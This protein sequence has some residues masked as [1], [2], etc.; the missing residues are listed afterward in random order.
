[1][2]QTIYTITAQTNL[3]AGSGDANYGIIDKL[4]QRDALTG[5]PCI[6]AS[7]L[8]G[9]ILQHCFNSGYD[10]DNIE[11]IFG[12]QPE[13]RRKGQPKRTQSQT[14]SHVFMQANLLSIPIRSNLQAFYEV[15]CPRIISDLVATLENLGFEKLRYESLSQIAEAAKLLPVVLSSIALTDCKLEDKK[16]PTVASC[17]VQPVDFLKLG[18]MVVPDSDFEKLTDNHHLPVI[19]RNYLENGQSANLWYEQVL[20][21]QTRF[22][23]GLMKKTEVA[24]FET[25][26]IDS[27]L[28]QIGANATVGYGYCKISKTLCNEN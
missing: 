15:T 3:H 20:P 7:S 25:K 12:G 14:G 1:M 13:K 6:H 26:L 21:R 9:S 19:A 28:V 23:F 11:T 27:G 2:A 5:L 17:N 16:Y 10:L 4:V 18:M 24:D 22:Y 8:K